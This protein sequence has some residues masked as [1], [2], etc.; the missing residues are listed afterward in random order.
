MASTQLD[1]IAVRSGRSVVLKPFLLGGV[2][3]AIGQV[4]NLS[5]TLSPA[6]QR[7]NRADVIRQAAWVGAPL[8]T[9]L[10]HPNRTVDALRVLLACPAEAWR[11]VMNAFF[12]AYWRDGLDIADVDVRASILDHLG[13]DRAEVMRQAASDAGRSALRQRTDEAV[14][15]GVFGAPAFVVD[16]AL[17]WGADRIEMVVAAA[18]YGFAPLAAAADFDFR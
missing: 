1:D 18:R 9:P 6:K 5:A 14:A 2:F 11:D 17:F 12:A 16:G 15:L 10:R 4:Q 3:A 8:A 7:H 13:L